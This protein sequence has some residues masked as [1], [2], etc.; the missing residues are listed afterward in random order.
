VSHEQAFILPRSLPRDRVICRIVDALED[1]PTDQGFRV[2][3]R[4]HRATRS[5]AQNAFLWGVVY[6]AILK[7]GGN[8][9]A[10]WS[11]EDLHEYCLGE[12]FGWE[13]VEGF[14]KK[15][16]RPL[17]RSSK[18]SKLEFMEYTA[19]IQQRMAEHGICVPDPNEYRHE[20]AA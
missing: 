9:L 4:E 10:G 19:F 5:S 13:I 18:L 20:A 12:H 15:R 2:E 1:L 14:G 16:Q 3:I 6:P 8:T 7:A 17:R 11:T